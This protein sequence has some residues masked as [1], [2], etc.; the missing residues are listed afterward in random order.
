VHHPGLDI[1][2]LGMTHVLGE[3]QIAHH[4]AVLV[5]P[6]MRPVRSAVLGA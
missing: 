5:P 4:R 2:L 3:C 1:A 6:C